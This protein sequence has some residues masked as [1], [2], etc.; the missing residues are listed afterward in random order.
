MK[1]PTAWLIVAKTNLHAGNENTSNFELIDQVIQRSPLSGLPCIHS[2]S[3]KGAI[4]EYATQEA[5]L[6]STARIRIFGIDK[7]GIKKETNKGNTIFCD[8]E[9]LLLP[10]QN[11]QNLYK[12]VSSE[13]TINRFTSQMELFGIKDAASKLLKTLDDNNL[14]Y[15]KK[16]H[17]E[18]MELCN[19][20]SLPIIA[21]NRLSNGKSDNLWYEQVL[22]PETVLGTIILPGEDTIVQAIKNQLIQIGANATIGYGFCKFIQII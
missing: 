21:R 20:E 12:L 1:N 11:N 7:S 8:A 22:P 14:S 3:L 4:N 5:D 9:M 6:S 17:K 16:P 2:S 10:E 13:A 18:F 15:E 19:D